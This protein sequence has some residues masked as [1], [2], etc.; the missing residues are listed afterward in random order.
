MLSGRQNLYLVGDYKMIR[1]MKLNQ[2]Y[3]DFISDGSKTFE[4]RLGTDKNKNLKIGDIIIFND[5]LKVKI[6]SINVFPSYEEAMDFLDFRKLIPDA[7][8]SDEAIKVYEEF[9]SKEKQAEFGVYI[10][11]I[12]LLND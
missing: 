6:I 4:G 7:E 12:E 9:Y 5:L 2:K 1:K 11:G 3:Y 10:F 8:N